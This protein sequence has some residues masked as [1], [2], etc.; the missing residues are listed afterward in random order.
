M[1]NGSEGRDVL[2]VSVSRDRKIRT[3]LRTNQIAGFIAGS[4]E[5]KKYI[6]EVDILQCLAKMFHFSYLVRLSSRQIRSSDHCRYSSRENR[7]SNQRYS[8]SLISPGRSHEARLR[9]YS[10]KEFQLQKK[11]QAVKWSQHNLTTLF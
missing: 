10:E 6:L 2:S 3:A 11:V 1:K 5:E 4:S 7:S 9:K 8:S